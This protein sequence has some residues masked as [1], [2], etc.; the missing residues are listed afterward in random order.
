MA[1]L[2]SDLKKGY[3]PTST[4]TVKKIFD[5][6]L[7]FNTEKKTIALDSCAGEGDVI[8][9]ISNNYNCKSYAVELDIVRAQK[10]M[11]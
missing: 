5:K 4:L 8:E 1:R 6:F 9:Y 11:N 10:A 3:Y 2:E 7:I